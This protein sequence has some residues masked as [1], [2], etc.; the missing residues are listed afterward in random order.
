M[1]TIEQFF[2][3]GSKPSGSIEVSVKMKFPR[4]N[5]EL[6]VV[7]EISYNTE[8]RVKKNSNVFKGK[9][10]NCPVAVKLRRK[11][12]YKALEAHTRANF[13]IHRNVVPTHWHTFQDSIL[14]TAE[15][16]YEINLEDFVKKLGN[17]KFKPINKLDIIDL[18]KQI[19]QGLQHYHDNEIPHGNLRPSNVLFSQRGEVGLGD[20]GFVRTDFLRK[21]SSK[22][23]YFCNINEDFDN[24]QDFLAPE[25]S[26]SPSTSCD[27]PKQSDIFS[28]GC[29]FH[30]TFSG[31]EYVFAHVFKRDSNARVTVEDRPMIGSLCG[32]KDRWRARLAIPLIRRMIDPDPQLRP[33]CEDILKHPL[34]WKK[35][36]VFDFLRTCFSYIKSLDDKSREKFCEK[37]EDKTGTVVGNWISQIKHEI[38]F[39]EGEF[40]SKSIISLLILVHET[41]RCAAKLFFKVFFNHVF[42]LVETI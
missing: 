16:L 36:K 4:V 22:S 34:F 5:N 2:S 1:C 27:L 24:F 23:F 3:K 19:T 12:V 39:A 31:G 35:D 7:G 37:A 18:C 10:K 41:V 33:H 6:K 38:N 11:S 42:F 17:S 8:K 25:C 20:G 29:L 14:Y 9:Y 28:L 26:S 32:I 30:Y 13:L 15:K 40:E 21:V